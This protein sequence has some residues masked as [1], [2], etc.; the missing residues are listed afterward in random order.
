MNL[1]KDLQ[2]Q[3][4]LTLFI[5]AHDLGTVRY[6][7]D[8]I[9]VMYLGQMVEK[10]TSDA[11]YGNPMH[12]YTQALLSSAL[13]F[14]PEE[15]SK[16]FAIAGEIPSPLN[17]PEGCRFHT[18]CPHVMDMCSA[19]KPTLTEEEADHMVSCYLFDP[20]VAGKPS[21]RPAKKSS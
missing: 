1:L 11:V 16:Q 8:N 18:R 6:M 3:F 10:G 20:S 13:P 12:P 15:A 21:K 7:S 14:D 5:I 19:T 17:P 9:G 2:K 4:G